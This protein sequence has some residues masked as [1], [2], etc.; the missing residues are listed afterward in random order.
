MHAV[1]GG[2]DG[3][4]EYEK[5]LEVFFVSLKLGLTSFGGPV[6]Y[7]G[8]FHNEYIVKRKW[9]DEQI[10]ADLIALCQLLPGPASSQLGISI[11][12]SGWFLC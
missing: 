2:L 6:A 5:L 10:Y 4:V 1:P 3:N 8:Y 12:T 7:L 11:G 9:K